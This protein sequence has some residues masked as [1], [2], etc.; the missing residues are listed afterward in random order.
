MVEI[1]WGK[2]CADALEKRIKEE[3]IELKEKKIFPT[4]TVLKIGEDKEAEAYLKSIKKVFE[5][6]EIKV[7]ERNYNEKISFQELMDIYRELRENRN[8]HG[9]LLLRPLP[10]HLE[11]SRAYAFLPEEKDI[12]GLSYINLGKL[13]AGEEC[14]IPC[15]PLAVMELLD[16]YNISLEGKDTVII[17][18]SISVGRPLSLLFLKRN[19][20]VTLCHSKTK[21]LSLYTK[22][23]EIVVSAV[24]KAGIIN[25]EMIREESI[26][27]DIGTNI[28]DGKLVG[29]VD[30]ERVKEKVKAITPVP[31]GVGV[32]TV[33]VLA[34]NLLEAVRK[35]ETGN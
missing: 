16:Y 13:F 21:D 3:V 31:G 25:E 19:A 6:L 32:I 10:A 15:T 11:S 8:I 35:N 33:R 5:K 14:F 18:R 26:L 20:T 28:V 7:D 30:F 2:P 23:A 22:R 12:E 9:I 4:L 17:G 24:G 27:I 34:K 1:L 29:D